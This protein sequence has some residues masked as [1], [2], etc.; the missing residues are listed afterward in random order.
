MEGEK[1]GEIPLHPFSPLPLFST[2][3]LSPPREGKGVKG[4]EKGKE[5]EWEDIISI[6]LCLLHGV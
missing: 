6:L 2:F 1:E 3:F 4:G 5:R